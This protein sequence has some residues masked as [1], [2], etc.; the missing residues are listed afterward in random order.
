MDQDDSGQGAGAQVHKGSIPAE[1]GGVAELEEG[2]EKSGERR[3]VGVGESEL[4]EVVDVGDAEVERG[5]EDDASWGDVGEDVEGDYGGAK[6]DFFG[7]R[8]LER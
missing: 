4:V 1:D 5:E 7:Y 6:H 2:A 8:A 3:G